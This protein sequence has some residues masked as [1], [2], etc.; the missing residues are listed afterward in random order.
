MKE[1]ITVIMELMPDIHRWA[2]MFFA[3]KIKRIPVSIGI[4][5]GRMIKLF[6][7]FLSSQVIHIVCAELLVCSLS[8]DQE[9][10]CNPK[11]DDDGSEDKCLRQRI[12]ICFSM[13][14]EKR[15]G[16]SLESSHCQ[17]EQ[18]GSVAQKTCPD[19]D[20]E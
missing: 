12:D 20:P 8:K 19:N 10:R 14:P 5:I 18:M 16:S 4:N 1:A 17:N 7:S 9:K 6:M 2:M 13:L 3:K 11:A 15:R